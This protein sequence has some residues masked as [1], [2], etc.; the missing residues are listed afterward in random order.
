MRKKVEKK[1]NFLNTN[2]KHEHERL[3]INPF[4]TILETWN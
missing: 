4:K 3:K 2:V 1:V